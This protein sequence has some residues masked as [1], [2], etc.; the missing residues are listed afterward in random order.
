M[1][2]KKIITKGLSEP[3]AS[4]LN[5]KCQTYLFF[6]NLYTFIVWGLMAGEFITCGKVVTLPTGL[7]GIYLAF[8]TAYTGQ[9]EI[10]RWKLDIS[11]NRIWGE[12]WVYIW[13]GTG[14]LL[15]GLYGV[16]GLLKCQFNTPSSELAIIIGTTITYF[17]GT[18][19]SKFAYKKSKEKEVKADEPGISK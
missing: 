5:E 19:L 18:E 4:W 16:Q 2:T 10:T 12:L 6:F 14:L 3:L 17:T 15:Y 13:L 11:Y 7:M 1:D 8:L 9:K